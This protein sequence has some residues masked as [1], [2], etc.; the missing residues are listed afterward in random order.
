MKSEQRLNNNTLELYMKNFFGY[1]TWSADVWFI[2]MEEGGGNTLNE[3]KSRINSWDKRGQKKLEDL[4]EYHKC[5]IDKPKFFGDSPVLQSTWSK[6]I[7]IF[8]S[9][10]GRPSDTGDVREYQSKKWGRC[11]GETCLLELFPLPSPSTNQWLYQ[12][13]SFLPFLINRT[14]YKHY[15][16]KD[17]SEAIRSKFKEY[18]PS[19]VIFYGIGYK[20]YW[21]G[22]VGKIFIKNDNPVLYTT[23][24]SGISFYIIP[25]PV[26]KGMKS[27][28]FE[29]IGRYIKIR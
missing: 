11:N 19:K 15:L 17:R 20:E 2:G 24:A 27:G 3:I 25:H 4:F 23:T 21:E 28:D 6:L 12:E 29:N 10:N 22:L 9:F 8:L 18:K 14:S 1:G 16:F 26:A 7:R 5:I 13:Y